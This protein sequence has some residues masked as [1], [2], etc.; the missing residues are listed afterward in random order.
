MRCAPA[1]RSASAPSSTGHRNRLCTLRTAPTCCR[2]YT[3][4]SLCPQSCVRHCRRS[5]WRSRPS[6]CKCPENCCCYIGSGTSYTPCSRCPRSDERHCHRTNWRWRPSRCRCR[7]ACGCCIWP[8][9]S[10]SLARSRRAAE[11][12]IS[13]DTLASCSFPSTCAPSRPPWTARTPSPRSYTRPSCRA[14]RCRRSSQS[15]CI[16]RRRNSDPRTRQYRGSL[17]CPRLGC[18]GRYNIR[19]RPTR[20]RSWQAAGSRSRACTGTRCPAPPC[21]RTPALCWTQRRS[22]RRPCSCRPQPPSCTSLHA[23]VCV[24]AMYACL[25]VRWGWRG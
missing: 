14:R 15:L 24:V 21:K 16:G 3:G 11:G 13:C 20:S 10:H 2:F 12:P 19:P 7:T 18:T 9:K 4:C 17:R 25:C 6:G 23:R 22:L 5:S 1:P 8:G